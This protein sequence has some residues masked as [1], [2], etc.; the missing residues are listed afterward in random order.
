M[1]RVLKRSAAD[2]VPP[3]VARGGKLGATAPR[4]PTAP[5]SAVKAPPPASR[6][7]ARAP[8][9]A[10]GASAPP[11]GALPALVAQLDAVF[12]GDAREEFGPDYARLLSRKIK[13]GLADAVARK[14]RAMDA[15]RAYEVAVA[16]KFAEAGTLHAQ[17]AAMRAAKDASDAKVAELQARVAAVLEEAAQAQRNESEANQEIDE[18]NVVIA[19]RDGIIEELRGT[20]A[21][22][23]GEMAELDALNRGLEDD[24][25][26]LVAKVKASE[27]KVAAAAAEHAAA[28]AKAQAH[29]LESTSAAGIRADAL[30][31]EAAATALQLAA[32]QGR[33][34]VRLSL[35]C[36]AGDPTL[37]SHRWL[38][39]TPTQHAP[40][41]P[42]TI[43]ATVALAP[44]HAAFSPVP[45]DTLLPPS[46][47]RRVRPAPRGTHP[48]PPQLAANQ[49]PPPPSASAGAGARRGGVRERQDASD[50]GARR[51][52][53]G[54]AACPRRPVPHQ[55]GPG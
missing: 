33:I 5:P 44:T 14:A 27:A 55:G 28:L 42:S 49:P 18:A 31:K 48:P 11:A 20:V 50:G 29:A 15:A 32:A 1:S 37:A 30:Q 43:P 24:K 12:H 9:V 21:R 41:P 19:E 54:A 6:T 26:E 2:N 7:P 45:H 22:L 10:T 40:P 46:P 47:L 38:C 13:A 3:P 16:A 35:H 53:G 17:L 51:S 25:E 52:R 23:E 4:A 39:R 34:K 36:D 8:V